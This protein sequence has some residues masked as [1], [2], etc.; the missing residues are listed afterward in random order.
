MTLSSWC[1]PR[2]TSYEKVCNRAPL[3]Q[4]SWT[5]SKRNLVSALRDCEAWYSVMFLLFWST[6]QLFKIIYQYSLS[7]FV[8]FQYFMK[9]ART[10]KI[11]FI[12]INNYCEY[13]CLWIVCIQNTLLLLGSLLIFWILIVLKT[14]WLLFNKINAKIHLKLSVFHLRNKENHSSNLI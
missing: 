14:L 9:N 7:V 1:F 4:F 10:I 8:C 13:Y 12:F 11:K 6:L 5:F 3:P 2:C